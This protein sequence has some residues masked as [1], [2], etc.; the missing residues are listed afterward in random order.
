MANNHIGV[1]TATAPR[2]GEWKSLVAM[3][4]QFRNALVQL[5]RALPQYGGDSA[6]Y[7]AIEADFG[8]PAGQGTVVAGLIPS[9]ASELTA[10]ISD[11]T[12]V[13]QLLDRAG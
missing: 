5:A 9:C 12:F 8:L 10:G 11:A 2:A 1:T 6:G 7:A 3:G 4:L 13:T